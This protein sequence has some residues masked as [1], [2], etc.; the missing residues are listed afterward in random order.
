MLLFWRVD[1]IDTLRNAVFS[2]SFFRAEH[3]TA[4]R[5]TAQSNL[6]EQGHA[7]FPL[8]KYYSYPKKSAMEKHIVFTDI[9]ICFRTEAA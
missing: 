6:I 7:G 4:L 1:F 2:I 9:S 3:I 5:Q 8:C